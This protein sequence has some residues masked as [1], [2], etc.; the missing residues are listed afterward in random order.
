LGTDWGLSSACCGGEDLERSRLARPTSPTWLAQDRTRR[1]DGGLLAEEPRPRA[2]VMH[3][4]QASRTGSK[5]RRSVASDDRRQ[6][7]WHH[8][9][10]GLSAGECGTHRR[11]R[12]A[13][14]RARAHHSR[15][16]A[17]PDRPLARASRRSREADSEALVPAGIRPRMFTSAAGS[18][19]RSPCERAERN[20]GW[21]CNQPRVLGVR[22]FSAA[23]TS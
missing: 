2:D 3:S 19:R 5:P 12:S 21:H 4:G 8:L 22:A 11:A 1:R 23:A 7:H 18:G 6:Q 20:F 17:P 13:A 16:Q 14:G 10:P 9:P 15:L